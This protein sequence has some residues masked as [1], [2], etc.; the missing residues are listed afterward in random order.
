VEQ[1]NYAKP[2]LDVSKKKKFRNKFWITR[3][4]KLLFDNEEEIWRILA[5]TCQRY[6]STQEATS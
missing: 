3:E 2:N 5:K 4:I 6:T 1:V